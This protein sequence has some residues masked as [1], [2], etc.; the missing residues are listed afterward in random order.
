MSVLSNELL[1]ICLL[2][3]QLAR[4]IQ[5]IHGASLHH[6][7]FSAVATIRGNINGYKGLKDSVGCFKNKLQIM[8]RGALL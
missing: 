1:V 5:H 4:K 6:H 3:K 2:A 7:Y 8:S